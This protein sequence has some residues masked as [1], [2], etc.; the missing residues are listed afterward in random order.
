MIEHLRRRGSIVA[1]HDPYV[2]VI[3]TAGE[4]W[5]RT[6]LTREAVAEAACVALLTPH[7][8]YDLPWIADTATLVFDAR[9]AYGPD[10]EGRTSS[11]CESHGSDGNRQQPIGPAAGADDPPVGRP[12]SVSSLSLWIAATDGLS[13]VAAMSIAFLI[14][15]GIRPIPSDFLAL[16]ALGPMVLV[17]FFAASRLYS[18]QL[19]SPAEEFRRVI[20]GIGTIIAAI[21]LFGFWSHIP[22]SRLWLG[23]TWILATLLCLV[24]RKRWRSAMARKRA[25]GSLAY[26]TLIVGA[27]HEAINVL[28]AFRS[29]RLGFQPVGM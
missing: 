12:R 11:A 13:M 3:E 18:V 14:R 22:Y 1:F 8:W 23:M 4:P 7:S 16:I 25:D 10:P 26:R 29:P 15:F 27:N 21:A 28:E 5:P 20:T 24:T 17:G 6:E 19:L 2:E 9:N